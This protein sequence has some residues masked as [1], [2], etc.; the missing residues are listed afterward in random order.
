M[1]ICPLHCSRHFICPSLMSN[2]AGAQVELTAPIEG[3]SALVTSPACSG[4]RQLIVTFG[5]SARPSTT[6][7]AVTCHCPGS[8]DKVCAR[9]AAASTG[10]EQS[11]T[12]PKLFIR[13]FFHGL[14]FSATGG[15]QSN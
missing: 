13:A 10:R 9:A 2:S 7:F 5:G 15:G 8:I 4:E 1:S 11:N 12:K 14:C 6:V 3:P